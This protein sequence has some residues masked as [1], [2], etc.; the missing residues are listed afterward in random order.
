[1]W[2]WT[3][4]KAEHQRIDALE[5]WCW[6]RLLRVPWTAR[7]SDQSIVRKSV[8]NIHWK[9]WYWSWNSNTLAT[10]C[11]ELTHLKR[12]WCWERLK[13]GGEGDNRGWDGWVAS[14]IRW[15]WVRVGSGSWWW[16]GKPVPDVL[17]SMGSQRV[18]HNWATELKDNILLLY[19]IYIIYILFLR[20][21]TELLESSVFEPGYFSYFWRWLEFSI[22]LSIL[23]DDPTL[24]WLFWTYIMDYIWVCCDYH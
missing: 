1:M 5:L 6:R 17:Q 3:I 10:W 14:V 9:D 19:I 23:V 16:T 21:L 13:A 15:T 20:S 8:L 4:K 12:P 22:P 18:G 2:E 24:W 11:E 7:R